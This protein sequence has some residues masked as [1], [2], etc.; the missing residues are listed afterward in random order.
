MEMFQRHRSG[1]LVLV[2]LP[3]TSVLT[4]VQVETSAPSYAQFV[5]QTSDPPRISTTWHMHSG[6]RT[7]SNVGNRT[8]TWSGTTSWSHVGNRTWASRTANQSWTSW[9]SRTW[10]RTY[11]G[12]WTFTQA[13]NVTWSQYHTGNKSWT[14][15]QQGNLTGHRRGVIPGLV[16]GWAHSNMTVTAKNL[17]QP[18]LLNG[19]EGVRLRFIA[20]NASSSG[21]MIRNVAIN[22]SVAQ[23]EFDYNGS[24][25]LTISSSVKPS[26]VFADG[27][28]L[29]EAQSPVGLTPQSEAWVYDSSNQTLTVFA[30][31][32]S[33]TLIYTPTATATTTPVPEYPTALYLTLIACLVTTILLTKNSRTHPRSVA[34]KPLCEVK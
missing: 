3:L 33:V 27:N 15:N 7:W 29:S 19:T 16:T 31:P 10:N 8:F 28:L 13:A 21:Q 26:L 6:S 30:D 24:I 1:W 25:Q 34:T 17:T 4:L 2:L 23:I 32:T 9:G 5:T 18:I 11:T 12:N 20:I 14:W 22:E